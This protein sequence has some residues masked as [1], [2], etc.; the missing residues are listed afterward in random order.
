MTP[1][2]VGK[3]VVVVHWNA[4]EKGKLCNVFSIEPTENLAPFHD[5]VEPLVFA[6]VGRNLLVMLIP[7]RH[8]NAIVD[9][10]LGGLSN[11]L[12]LNTVVRDRKHT[13]GIASQEN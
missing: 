11:I 8:E 9:V 12:V 3:D 7:P 10:G 13:R 6:L 4:A 2:P 5:F 1:Y